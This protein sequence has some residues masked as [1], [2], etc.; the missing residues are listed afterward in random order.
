MISR[1]SYKKLRWIDVESPTRAEIDSLREEFDLPILIAEELTT[2][3]LRSKVDAYEN[4]LY[5]ILHF[6]ENA[7]S[8]RRTREQ[9][10]DFVIGTDFLIT[11]HY[12]PI[13]AL[14]SF[15][16]QFEVS[17]ILEKS[18]IGDH[19]GY[20]LYYLLR[21]LYADINYSLEELDSAIRTVEK[22][23]FEGHEDTMVQKIS[24]LNRVL[25]DFQ[26]ALRF[27][28]ETLTSF[29][30]AGHVF[31]GDAFSYHL[32][33]MLSEFNKI[34]HILIGHKT[35]LQDLRKTNDSLLSSKTSKTIKVLTVLNSIMAP[36]SLVAFILSMNSK[37]IFIRDY[38][39]L[40][41]VLLLMAFI[42]VS[43]TLY[44]KVKKWF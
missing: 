22:S 7:D 35:I 29:E 18:P 32:S 39:D 16:K 13:N 19:S 41:L 31:F 40:T 43:M 34:D 4:V 12:T 3:P 6:P 1:Y 14:H 8:R 24:E 11:V 2:E 5:M 27:H 10:I 37:I 30:Q 36:I 9:E 28:R 17:S 23:I 33:L 26:Q 38:Q 42:G 44:F 20:L 25:V 21:E 15:A